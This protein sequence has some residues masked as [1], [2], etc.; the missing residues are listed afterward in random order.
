MSSP[1]AI[2]IWFC[3]YLNCV[4]WTLSALHQLNKTGYVIAFVAGLAV[5]WIWKKKAGA[6]L[7]PP[8]HFS[9]YRRRFTKIFP[10]AFLVLVVL[11]FLGGLLHQPANYDGLAYRTTRVL[12]WLAAGEWQW[13]HSDFPR[14]N[15]RTAGWEW[16]T[17]PQILFLNT[18]RLVFLL[19]F[20]SFVLLPGRIFAVLTRL[21]VGPRAAWHWMWI[22]PGGYGYVLQAGSA[23]NDLFGTTLTL[24][25]FEFALRARNSGK[26]SEVW[27]AMLAAA[28]MTAV[29]AFNIVLLLPW[30]I[31]IFPALQS[32]LRRPLA[33]LA[34][35]V[36]VASASMVPTSVLNLKY[37]GDWTGAKIECTPIGG[38]HELLRCM[39][40]IPNLLLGNFVPP[41]FP[42]AKRLEDWVQ[43]VLSPQA[44]TVLDANFEGGT[45]HFRVPELQVE[46]TSGLG[47]G[48]SILMLALLV[49]K[50]RIREKF[51]TGGCNVQTLVPLA[52]WAGIG[53]FL[54]RVGISGPARYLLPFYVLLIAPLLAGQFA[55]SIFKKK[56]WRVIALMTFALAAFLLVVSPPRPLWPAITVLR[57]IHAEEAGHP[58]LNRLWDVY[59]V[60]GSRGDAFSP[61]VA[62]LPLDAVR[63]GFATFD[64]PETSLWRP[65]GARQIVHIPAAETADFV[66]ALRLKYALVSGSFL[67]HHTDMDAAGWMA[68]FRAEPMQKF[69]LRIHAGR[70]A[71]DFYLVRFP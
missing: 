28:L 65:F 17:A 23:V 58:L 31:A 20:I 14:L 42:P 32:L 16:L 64:E 12:H 59:S 61:I 33:T 71:E 34:V 53:I 2:W 18:D 11:S 38:G 66:R 62:A 41:V 43:T 51:F 35:A 63:L 9:K 44:R 40:N 22:I 49:A 54:I 15:T 50:L 39:V 30:A 21:G 45:A 55:G 1:V 46:E 52:A 26:V 48:V 3:A 68:R 56:T 25:A 7:L 5:V 6:R 57:A 60:Y 27:I 36:L 47:F 70:D 8:I 19:S 4:G 67:A 10:A 24:A 13:V 37:C 29:K 69:K